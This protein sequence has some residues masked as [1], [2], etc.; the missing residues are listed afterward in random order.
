MQP[1]VAALQ[2]KT[3]PPITPVQ[4]VVEEKEVKPRGPVQVHPHLYLTLEP[5]QPIKVSR[6]RQQDGVC[7]SD[8]SR[9][10]KSA[11]SLF[12]FYRHSLLNH[13]E[14]DQKRLWK[15]LSTRRQNCE[16]WKKNFWE[17]VRGNLKKRKKNKSIERRLKPVMRSM[18]RVL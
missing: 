4:V 8:V 14:T 1:A 13:G 10:I 9:E 2:E 15:N 17:G 12:L 7:G 11:S 6:L 3:Q 5:L 16:S 18:V